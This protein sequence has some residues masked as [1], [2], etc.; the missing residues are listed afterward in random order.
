MTFLS[1]R[2]LNIVGKVPFSACVHF[3]SRFTCWV[4]SLVAVVQLADPVLACVAQAGRSEGD[5]DSRTSDVDDNPYLCP[6]HWDAKR[7]FEFVVVAEEKPRSIRRR[8][9]FV[10]AIDDAM[11]RLVADDSV[12]DPKKRIARLATA[13]ALHYHARWD[14]AESDHR[15]EEIVSELAQLDD[16][17]SRR[18]VAFYQ[19]ERK[20]IEFKAADDHEDDESQPE[21]SEDKRHED[22]SSES[23]NTNRSSRKDI[24][25]LLDEAF[26]FCEKTE[27]GDRHLRL[28]SNIV[29]I[30]NLIDAE[31][32]TDKGQSKEALAAREEQFAR[33]GKL[34]AE[35]SDLKMSR[36]GNKLAKP[37]ENSSNFVGETMEVV[38]LALD[39]TK[40]D[41]SDYKGRVV[42]VDFWATWC[43]PC[44]R[45]LP[46]LMAL[47][48][49]LESDGLD[50]IGISLD[51]EIEDLE[52]FV[53]D[54][55][56]GWQNIFGRDAEGL[57]EK[58]GVR[59]I[60]TMFLVGKDG[61]VIQVA[62]GVRELE[63][64]I[65]KAL[66]HSE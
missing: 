5:S 17:R 39:E 56:L 35:S 4:V 21:T 16:K 13:A 54:K 25:S 36:Y 48:D 50:V 51:R 9:P 11:R 29:R 62:N 55:N 53:K 65:R 63:P 18:D 33:F 26:Q 44:L 45:E 3:F 22:Q 59:G 57:S 6:Q 58:Y 43:G 14:N 19:L 40:V 38:G 42:V 28:A 12:S 41:I 64:A 30:A 32:E 34:F 20:L 27:L 52:S 7:L 1:F 31:D 46:K 66:K 23:L 15:L 8:E 49:E 24:T 37:A 2:W 47:Y 10:R 61:K 60:P